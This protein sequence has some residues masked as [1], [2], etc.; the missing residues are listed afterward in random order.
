MK[1]VVVLAWL[2][3]PACII[4]ASG[5]V[6]GCTDPQASNYNVL[7]TENDG[8][9]I[10]A[11]T[12]LS[13]AIVCPKLNDSLLETSGLIYFG[14][15]F[16][17]L[18]DSDNPAVLYAFDSMNGNILHRIYIGNQ[19]NTDWE[20][21]AQD[22]THIYVGDF[23][24]NLGNRKDLRV[25]VIKKSDIDLTS[26][27]DT[28]TASEI[29]FSLGDQTSFNH[30]NQ[31]HDFDLEAFCSF[32]DSLHLFSKN[33]VD[34]QTRHY[35]LPKIPGTYAV[36]P[37]ESF[38]VNG[39]VTG[40]GCDEKRGVMVLTGYNLSDISCFIWIL[41]DLDSGFFSKGNK[42]RIELGTVASFGQNEAVCF[43]GNALYLSN[44]KYL[45]EASLRRVEIDRFISGKPLAIHG[46]VKEL[47]F[48]AWQTGHTL[49]IKGKD[50]AG[51][52]LNIHNSDGKLI[53]SVKLGMTETSI[54]VDELMEGVFLLEVEENVMKIYIKN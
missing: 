3:L 8:S 42:R 20:D 4:S 44:E 48:T 2:F 26:P 5:Q 40:A 15:R 24:N 12:T 10:Y 46:K 13:P 33:W 32:G 43:K 31:A 38:S 18:N 39:Q 19:T 1:Y 54:N 16:W 35:V 30:T 21:L 34:K 51:K 27:A 49:Y 37:R 36:Y 47:T 29:H 22:S 45:T 53:R 23:G 52:T 11:K 7:A 50:I 41:W 25:L 14:N 9:C 28:V 6:K 17:T